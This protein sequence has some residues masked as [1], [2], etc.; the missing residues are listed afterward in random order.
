MI[1]ATRCT[2]AARL[3][4]SKP[5]SGH[6]QV[7]YFVAVV[8]LLCA[9]GWTLWTGPG[10][11]ADPASAVVWAASIAGF[12]YLAR[13]AL[14]SNPNLAEQI[15]D[16]SGRLRDQLA[17]TDALKKPILSFA[18]TGQDVVASVK[19]VQDGTRVLISQLKAMKEEARDAVAPIIA[20]RD[21]ALKAESDAVTGLMQAYRTLWS[22]R[23]QGEASAFV[24]QA[25][26]EFEREH[27]PRVGVSLIN[28]V[29]VTVDYRLH[30]VDGA[31]E[32]SHDVPAGA[33]LRVVRPGFRRRGEVVG[34]ADVVRACAANAPAP[35]E[36][37]ESAVVAAPE[38]P[39][40][41]PTGGPDIRELPPEPQGAD[42]TTP[43]DAN[44][45]A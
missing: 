41:Q 32:P 4:L 8:P 20:D 2:A 38:V 33:V 9:G 42:T 16:A 43:T 10:H 3:V 24:E 25:A 19:E 7:R 31:D 17:S 15:D 12:V 44:G 11:A 40:A 18:S 34:R 27:L 26:T 5:S 35:S 1:A 29:G 22:L 6:V 30:Q 36:T 45:D 39:G 13:A 21:R 28:E 37:L 23:G 14:S